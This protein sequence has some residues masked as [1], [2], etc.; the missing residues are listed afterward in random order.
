MAD[1]NDFKFFLK[2]LPFSIAIAVGSYFLG[3]KF[4]L[5]I[6]GIFIG[7][8]IGVCIMTYLDNKLDKEIDAAIEKAKEEFNE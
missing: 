3:M 8:I 4:I 7:V 5:F 6:V 2:T 1:Y